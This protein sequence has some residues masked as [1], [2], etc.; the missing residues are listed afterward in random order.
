MEHGRDHAGDPAVAVVGVFLSASEPANPAPARLT[1]VNGDFANL[2]PLVGQLFFIGDGKT[3]TGAT[4]RFYAP[5]GA[6]R[7]AFGVT[8]LCSGNVIGCFNDNTGAYQVTL[9]VHPNDSF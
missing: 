6:T 8:D 9:S 3:S 2:H 1:F 4:Q 7:L 5:A